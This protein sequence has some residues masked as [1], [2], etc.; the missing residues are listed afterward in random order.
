M[1]IEGSVNL[2]YEKFLGQG[3]KLKA[4]PEIAAPLCSQS[5]A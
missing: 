2:N 1:Y 4:L 3:W 5:S